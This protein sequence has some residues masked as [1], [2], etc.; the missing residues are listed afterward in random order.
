MTNGNVFQERETL[1]RVHLLFCIFVRM[2]GLVVFSLHGTYDLKIRLPAGV[3]V[4]FK[5][6]FNRKMKCIMNF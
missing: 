6:I 4:K 2:E 5:L 1:A 3:S